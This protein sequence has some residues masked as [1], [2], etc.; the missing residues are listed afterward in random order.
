M[1][2]KIKADILVFGKILIS[3]ITRKTLKY[4]YSPPEIFSLVELFTYESLCMSKALLQLF[5]HERIVCSL[6][7]FCALL[8]LRSLGMYAT[9]VPKCVRI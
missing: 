7:T 6:L 8:V 1:L 4:R 3:S 5:A 9:I 2:F